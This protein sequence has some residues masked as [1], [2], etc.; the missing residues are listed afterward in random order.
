VRHPV[1]LAQ[2]DRA[3]PRT[4]QARAGALWHRFII[5]LRRTLATALGIPVR[6]FRDHA[7]LSYAKVAEYQRRGLV[8]FHA[9]L[10][11][12]GLNG[13]A[14]PTSHG[15]TADVLRDAVRLAA[16]TA[17]LTVAR[18]DGTA[19]VLEWG[20]VRPAARPLRITKPRC[21]SC[22]Q[23]PGARFISPTATIFSD[24]SHALHVLRRRPTNSVQSAL[25]TITPLESYRI[26][27]SSVQ[28]ACIASHRRSSPLS[29]SKLGG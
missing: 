7:R 2:P 11:L 19:L 12:D 16:R 22:G 8:H 26:S 3:A 5:A 14:D 28:S 4:Q 9:V 17:V 21:A 18:P 29:G 1:D 27:R 6:A 23:P 20:R 24:Q 15:F 13:P 25:L 10:R